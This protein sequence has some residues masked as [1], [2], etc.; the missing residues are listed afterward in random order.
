MKKWPTFAKR[1]EAV[2][3]FVECCFGVL[4]ARFAIIRNPCHQWSMEVIKDIMFTCCILHN[5]IME[6]EEDVEGLEDI[7]PELQGHAM[8]FQRGL[9]FDDLLTSPIEIENIDAHY[10]LRSNII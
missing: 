2:W 4:Q 8:P 5:M 6:D 7:I 3:K 10:G 9:T 1:Q